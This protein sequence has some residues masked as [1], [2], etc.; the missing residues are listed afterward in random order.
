MVDSFLNNKSELEK[1]KLPNILG[2]YIVFLGLNIYEHQRYHFIGFRRC[3][4]QINYVFFNNYQKK[5]VLFIYLF[6]FV[7]NKIQFCNI[8]KLNILI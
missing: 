2:K 3:T 6:H 4:L 5:S 8:M 1:T 7:Y